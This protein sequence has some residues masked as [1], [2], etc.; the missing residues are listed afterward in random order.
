M[1]TFFLC[2]DIQTFFITWPCCKIL[3]IWPALK[4]HF[5]HNKCP[6]LIKTIIR[7]EGEEKNTLAYLSFINNF[8][9]SVEVTMNKI[10]S[11]ILSV[12]VM[13]TVMHGIREKI[14]QRIKNKFFGSQARDIM[15][16]LTADANDSLKTDFYS[17][18]NNFIGYLL[19]QYD[20]SENNILFKILF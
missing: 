8:M 20:F 6:R 14:E 2:N 18:Y 12:V 7:K 9:F 5:H 16:G 15:R 4:S 3:K 17:L 11:D 13:H 1:Q 19:S 10:E